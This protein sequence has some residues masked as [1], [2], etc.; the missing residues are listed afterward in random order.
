[1]ILPESS[2]AE[3]V[4]AKHFCERRYIVRPDAGVA[5]KG[6]RKFHNGTGVV[7]VMVAAGEQGGA[8]GRTE[9]SCVKGIVP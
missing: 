9:R 7:H 1:M 3:S 2:G 8:R 6:R 5:R 4:Q